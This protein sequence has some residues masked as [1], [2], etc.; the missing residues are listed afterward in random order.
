MGGWVG[1]WVEE[2]A[3][4]AY[5]VVPPVKGVLHEGGLVASRKRVGRRPLIDEEVDGGSVST[6]GMWVG[7]WV[8]G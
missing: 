6:C 1:G 4:L 7:G 3:L 2:G 8:G 5:R